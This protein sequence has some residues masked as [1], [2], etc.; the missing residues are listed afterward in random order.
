V[1]SN[2]INKLDK[3]DS[4]KLTAQKD[5]NTNSGEV[6]LRCKTA[7]NQF[8]STRTS[9][10]INLKSSTDTFRVTTASAQKSIAKFQVT[11]GSDRLK[12]L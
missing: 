10:A 1:A 5:T 9:A 2:Y 4:E 11:L 6:N 12:K 7:P 8:S 3:A